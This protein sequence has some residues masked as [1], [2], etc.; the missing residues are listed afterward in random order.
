ML[1]FHEFMQQPAGIDAA[2]LVITSITAATTY[3]FTGKWSLTMFL[4]Y[5]PRRP[6]LQNVI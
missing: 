3:H 5:D 4:L 1:R 2:S 6:V